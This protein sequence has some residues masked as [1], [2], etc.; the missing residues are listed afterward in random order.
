ML[1]D[2]YVLFGFGRY[3]VFRSR[4]FGLKT[5]PNIPKQVSSKHLLLLLRDKDLP[6]KML[7]NNVPSG[8]NDSIPKLLF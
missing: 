7:F 1:W 4:R 5:P 6:E 3:G 2:R 8:E